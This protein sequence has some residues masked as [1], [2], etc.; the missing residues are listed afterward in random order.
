MTLTKKT[1]HI[2]EA[3][4]NLIFEFQEESPK[5]HALVASYVD[6]IQD[7]ENVAFELLEDRSLD[8]AEGEQLDGL[9]QIV[10]LER[11]GLDDDEYRLRLRVQIKLNLSA[12]TIENVIE[13]A[14]LITDEPVLLVE[15]Y[16]ATILITIVN[17]TT[18]PL[19]VRRIINEAR[20]AGVAT[21]LIYSPYPGD[22]TFQFSSTATSE[23][24]ADEGFANS[25]Q[26][27]GGRFAGVLVA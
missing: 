25:A 16:P 11:G 5:L 15:S 4:S 10:G 14:F 12:G 27:T 19:L 18:D 22:E 20:S 2:V 8:T 23:T 26:T 21:Q 24:D 13:V 1:N 17:V 7:L 3:I 6:Q 9:G